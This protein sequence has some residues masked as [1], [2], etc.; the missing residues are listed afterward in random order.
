ML[1]YLHEMQRLWMAPVRAMAEGT[2]AAL[3]HPLNPWAHTLPGRM[4][5]SVADIFEHATQRYGK[6]EWGLD[7]TTIDG[8]TVE[9]EEEALIRRTY[10]NLLHF[11]R[12][13]DR[14]DPRVLIV[15]P[16]SGHF[17][18]LLRGTVAAMLPDHDVYVTD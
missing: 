3:R 18:T 2:K 12:D 9:I 4:L 1:Y 7:A 15:A 6:P 11:K 14:A 10:C 16:M 13:T 17:A 8:A 5:G